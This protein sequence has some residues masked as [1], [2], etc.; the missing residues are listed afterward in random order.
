MKKLNIY[1]VIDGTDK[2]P[3]IETI[4]AETSE[5]CIDIA[6]TKYGSDNE[7]HWTNPY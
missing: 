5:E 4:E 2:W 3:L 7:Y 6:E 1:E